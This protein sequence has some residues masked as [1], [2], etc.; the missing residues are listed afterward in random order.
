MMRRFLACLLVFTGCAQQAFAAPLVTPSERV[1]RNVIVRPEPG[2][3]V[4]LDALDPGETAELL[5]ELP[6]WYRIQLPNG[7]TGYV[8]K[9]WTVLS[10]GEALVAFAGQ[11]VKAH[12]IDVGTGLATFIEGPGFTMLYD[13]GS[14]D[15]LADGP[16]NRVVAYIRA[17]RPDVRVIDHLILS[18][19]HKDH[20]ELMPDVFDAFEI[21]NVWDSGAI[22]KTRG[23]CRFLKKVAAE[24]GVKYHDAIGSGGTHSVTF[25]G[26]SC[27][28]TVNIPEAAMMPDQPVPLGSAASM[29]FLFRDAT[30]HSDPNENTVVVRIEGGGRQLPSTKPAANSIEAELLKHPAQLKADALV[31]GHH[32]S[33]TSS[34][35]DFINAVD[36]KIYVISSGPH[37]YSGVVLPD[38]EIETELRSSGT[39][40]QTNLKD[41]QCEAN[42]SKIGPDA[43]ESPG[44]CDSVIITLPTSGTVSAAYNHAAD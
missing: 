43:D 28:G 20:L 32:G 37:P 14:Q 29:S 2:S 9:S 22:N 33:K 44:G 19:P 27:S 41:D 12:V 16:D 36:A 18:H 13:A 10:D 17:V 25:K 3:S 23:Y 30:H 21:R 35:A 6:G 34:R 40:Y 24:Q 42:E 7:V 4:K 8:S 1:K 11:P 5:Q 31:V 38:K 26:K 15:D 39:L